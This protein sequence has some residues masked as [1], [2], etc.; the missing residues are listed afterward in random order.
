[1]VDGEQKAFMRRQEAIRR[2]ENAVHTAPIGQV[3]FGSNIEELEKELTK[4]LLKYGHEMFDFRDGR[5]ITPLNVAGTI[6]GELQANDITL[7]NPRLRALYDTYSAVR[8]EVGD[9]VEILAHHFVTHPDPEV[10]NAAV[11]LLTADDVYTLSK[12]WK[13]HDF[14]DA[15]E[16]DRLGEALPR[17]V[18]LYKSKIIDE[19]STELRARLADP[20]LSDSESADIIRRITALAR[21]RTSISKRLSRLIL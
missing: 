11:D 19:L 1:V 13:R 2:A 9:G 20:E 14:S 5:A 3:A 21:E 17:A 4:Y 15:G 12:L 7:R 18:I 16:R 8:N 6:I 10:C